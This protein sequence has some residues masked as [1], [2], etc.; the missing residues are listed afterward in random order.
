MK[1]LLQKVK[2]AYVTVNGKKTG[3]IEKGY[4]LLVGIHKNSTEEDAKYLAK[5]ISEARLFED[6]NDKIN[7]GIKDVS[8]EILS[9]SQFTL[10]ANTKKGK[11]PSFTDAAEPSKAKELYIKF[12]QFL[13]ENSLTV[14][15]GIF[16]EHME[17]NIVNDGPM[18]V[19][20]EKLT[21]K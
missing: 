11:R 18:T 17:V 12:N 6:E 21:G 7:L 1:V 2:R 5:K 4:C 3:E 9:I 14:K 8:G 20:Y 13:E 15:T 19:E 16:Q 10:Y